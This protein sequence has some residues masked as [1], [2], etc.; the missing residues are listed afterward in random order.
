MKL[1]IAVEVFQGVVQDVHV[2]KTR[3]EAEKWFKGYTGLSYENYYAEPDTYPE[4]EEGEYNE[5]YEET[6]IFEAEVEL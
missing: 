5:D 4:V 3:E 2:F 1:W 6:K